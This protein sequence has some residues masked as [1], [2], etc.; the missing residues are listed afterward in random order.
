MAQTAKGQVSYHYDLE[1]WD[2]FDIPEVKRTP[3]WDGHTA[4]DV[5][6]RLL[7]LAVA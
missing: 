1:H 4:T 2:Q 3:E 5:V 6:H 7:T